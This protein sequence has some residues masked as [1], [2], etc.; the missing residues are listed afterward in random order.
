MSSPPSSTSVGPR[1]LIEPVDSEDFIA[2]QSFV[3]VPHRRGDGGARARRTPAEIIEIV[4][5]VDCIGDKER[6]AASQ[7]AV[8]GSV[9]RGEHLPVTPIR[10]LFFGAQGEEGSAEELVVPDRPVPEQ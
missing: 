2:N 9:T 10:C 3:V 7:D 1:K 8:Y 5:I 6:A 4:P